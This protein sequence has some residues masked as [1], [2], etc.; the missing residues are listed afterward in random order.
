MNIEDMFEHIIIPVLLA[1]GYHPDTIKD[2]LA[3]A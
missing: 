2:Y 1:A 3:E